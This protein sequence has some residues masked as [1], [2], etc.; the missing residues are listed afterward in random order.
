MARTGWTC[1]W[2]WIRLRVRRMCAVPNLEPQRDL[3][4]DLWMLADAFF[5]ELCDLSLLYGA[6]GLD[7]KRHFSDTAYTHL[8]RSILEAIGMVTTEDD[9]TPAQIDYTMRLQQA[10]IPFLQRHWAQYTVLHDL[11]EAL[12]DGSD[13]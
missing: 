12:R 9:P 6:I 8:Y 13:S 2:R 3:E 4:A 5:R 11:Q 1:L 10:F 7:P